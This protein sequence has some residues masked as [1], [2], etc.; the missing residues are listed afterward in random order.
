MAKKEV[1]KI[2]GSGKKNAAFIS[3]PSRKRIQHRE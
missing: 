1:S 2:V 3:Y